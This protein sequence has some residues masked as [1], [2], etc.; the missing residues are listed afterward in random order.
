MNHGNYAISV[1]DVVKWLGTKAEERGIEIY[2]GFPAHLPLFDGKRVVGVQIQDKGIDKDGQPKGVFE[3]GPNIFAKCVIFGEG[4]RGS[5]TKVVIDKL[6]LQG[7][8]PQSYETGI[9]EIWRIK[10]E[11]HVPGRVVH[12]MGWPQDPTTFGGGW[13]YDLKDNC[14]SIG[15]VTGLDYDNPYTDPHDLM[16]RWKTH[17]RMK[18]LLE[19]GECIRYGAKTMPVGGWFSFPKLYA[20]GMLLIGDSA[21]TCNGERLKGVHLAIKSGMLAAETLV[22]AIRKDDFSEATLAVV[23]DALRRELARE[24]ALEGAQ[25]PRAR[26]STCRRCRAGSAGCASCRGSSTARRSR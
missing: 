5:C 9:K 11:N 14:V 8:N 4:T 20:D 10:P 23:Q 13:I 15:F 7:P 6:G 22:E 25:L 16:Q 19:G 12:T 18:K 1:S 3:P 24:G 21:G 2:P 17:P 26:S